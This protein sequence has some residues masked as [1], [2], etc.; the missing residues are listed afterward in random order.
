VDGK[1]FRAGSFIFSGVDRGKLDADAKELGL[2]VHATSSEMKAPRHRLAV[3]RIALMHSWQRTQDDGWY[4]IAMDT[5]KI[6]YTYIPDTVVRETPNLRSLFDVVIIPALRGQDLNSMLRGIRRP[7][8]PMPWRNTPEMPNLHR[9]G[10]SESDDIRGGLGYAGLASLQRFVS[11][12]GLLI[13]A[14]TTVTVPVHGGMT[15][16]VTLAEPPNLQA[17][18]S[19][20]LTNIEDKKSP[21]AYGYDDKLYVYFRQGPLLRVGLGMG[22]G[23]FGQPD[24]PPQRSSGRGSAA[25]PDVIQGRRYVEPEPPVRRAPRQQELYIPDELQD[26]VRGTLPP[27]SQ[28][29]RVIA[30]FAP[31][32]ELLLSGMLVG[33]N[34]VAERPAVVHVPSGKGNVLLFANVPMWRDNTMG[35]FFLM[36]NAM[37]N[38]DHLHLGAENDEEAVTD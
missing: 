31:E 23:P 2:Q 30:R 1:K 36:F 24:G 8:G 21:I 7:G 35:S 11:E 18:G 22:G 9:P 34:Q 25:D 26:F 17:P 27:R 20:L 5:L 15:D 19:V 32:K 4:R 10:L 16:M 37:L 33:G 3:P 29:P 12:G 13:A 14:G 6:P 28:W 38:Y